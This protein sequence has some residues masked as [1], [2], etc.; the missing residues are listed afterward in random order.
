MLFLLIPVVRD[1]L[2]VFFVRISE[3]SAGPLVMLPF[4]VLIILVKDEMCWSFVHHILLAPTGALV[5]MMVYYIYIYPRQL[6]QI[7]TQSIDAIDVTSVTPSRLNSII[8]HLMSQ[9]AD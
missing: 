7:F 6:F 2:H 4:S 5:V 3:T 8:M 9:D 1:D